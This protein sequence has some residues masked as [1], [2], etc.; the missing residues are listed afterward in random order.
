MS[1]DWNT[2][3]HVEWTLAFGFSILNIMFINLILSGDNAVLIAMA[4]KNLPDTQR[5]SGIAFVDSGSRHL[6]DCFNFFCGSS[7]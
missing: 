5:K 2:L 1:F 3:F 7:A 6:E 4:V